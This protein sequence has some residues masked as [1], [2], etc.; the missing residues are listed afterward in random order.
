[1]GYRTG[2]RRGGTKEHPLYATYHLMLKRCNNPKSPNY[3]DYGGRGIK[4]CE[5]W[6]GENGFVF[7]TDDMGIRPIKFQLDRI[8][9]NGDYCPEN[10]R[11]VNKYTQMGNTR[12][13]GV[14]P[15]VSFM[16][17]KNKWRAR[18]KVNGVE[19]HLGL[20]KTFEEAVKCRLLLEKQY[21]FS[22]YSYQ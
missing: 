17:S 16:V 20:F 15:G 1:M 9:V 7:F 10:C 2:V 6:N 12:K 8:D 21:V 13:S 14:V 19:K 3:K 11:W 5:R 4:V 18:I 22:D